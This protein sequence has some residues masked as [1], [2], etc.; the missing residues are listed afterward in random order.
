MNT[1]DI[2]KLLL[3]IKN[4]KIS[5]EDGV[6]ILQD[7]PFKDL[8]YAKIDNHREI[9]VGYPE[10]IYCAGKTVD[11]IKGIVEFMLTKENN[12]L[13]TRATKEAY[14]EVKKICPDAEYNEL[15]RTIVIKK[16]ELKSK[17]GY[18][19]VVTAGTSDIPVSEEAAVTAEIFGNKVE[20]IYDV[21]VAGIH[22]LFDKLELIRGARVIVV[23]AGMEGALASVVGG[24]VDKPVIAV[25]TSIGY[26]ANFHGLSAL[27]SMLN[28]CASGVSV[29][30][31][32]NGF[33]AGYLAS[34]I[35]NL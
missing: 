10:V 16:R 33:G 28:S 14:E 12:I 29:V 9:R 23:A 25:P 19:A 22:R 17:G 11:Q 27:L 35:N 4:D 32:D 34:M 24:L 30:N 18:I 31:I 3:D 7:L 1:E 6:N 20:R 8:G 2:K 21:G 5:L 26:G 13:G 15:A